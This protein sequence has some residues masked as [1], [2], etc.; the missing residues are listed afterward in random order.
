MNQLTTI[1]RKTAKILIDRAIELLA[2]LADEYGVTIAGKGGTMDGP[3]F[4]M[5]I[6]LTCSGADGQAQ[7]RERRDF[8]VAASLYGIPDDALDKTFASNG[9]TYTLCGAKLGSPKFPFI[10]KRTDGK[11]FKFTGGTIARA[12]QSA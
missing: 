11:A 3:A 12:F 7:T 6:G 4:T 9:G 2:P 8:A 5:K 10:A 1:D